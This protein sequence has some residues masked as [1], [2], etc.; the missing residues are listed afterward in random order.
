MFDKPFEYFGN[1]VVKQMFRQYFM[2]NFILFFKKNIYIF[3]TQR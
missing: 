1:K 2:T 3:Q